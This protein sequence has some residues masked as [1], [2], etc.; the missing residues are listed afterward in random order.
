MDSIRRLSGIPDDVIFD[1]IIF[2]NSGLSN[3]LFIIEI[4]DSPENVNFFNSSPISS[5]KSINFCSISCSLRNFS[6]FVFKRSIAGVISFIMFFI[7][8]SSGQL[9]VF[10]NSIISLHEDNNSRYLSRYASSIE[11]IERDCGKDSSESKKPSQSR[12]CIVSAF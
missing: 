4:S 3:P 5:F 8:K 10:N 11:L 2:T 1:F 12:I 6:S 7:S 9:I